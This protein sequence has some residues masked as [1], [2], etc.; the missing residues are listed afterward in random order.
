MRTDRIVSLPAVPEPASWSGPFGLS[1]AEALV[2]VLLSEYTGPGDTV[3]DP[4]VGYGTTLVVAERMGRRGLGV[5]LLADRAEHVRAL[6]ERPADVICHDSRDLEAL[7]LPLIDASISSPPYM[8]RTRHPENPLT[9]YLT[10]DGDYNRYLSELGGVYRSVA[11]L[12]RDGGPVLV[13]AA[14]MEVEGEET[15][16]ADDLVGVLAGDLPLVEVIEVKG[17]TPPRWMVTDHVLVFRAC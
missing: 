8:T 10:F 9:G 6:V 13:N 7:D 15:R 17:P 11:G 14:T 1:F 16:L 3:L 12:V 4:F 5:E 2:A